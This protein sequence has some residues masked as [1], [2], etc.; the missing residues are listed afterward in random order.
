[1]KKLTCSILSLALFLSFAF[2]LSTFLA[3]AEQLGYSD[4][5]KQSIGLE[6]EKETV[7]PAP[8]I[9]K[10]DFAAMCREKVNKNPKRS[11]SGLGM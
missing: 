9:S 11:D 3:S 5:T 6:S 4:S 2:S 10:S 7:I 8:E 1:M